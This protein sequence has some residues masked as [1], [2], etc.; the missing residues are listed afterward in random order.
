MSAD[1]TEESTGRK[2]GRA[3]ILQKASIGQFGSYL[4][5][6]LDYKWYASNSN[7]M[8]SV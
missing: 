8:P 5:P 2:E 1:S 4:R 6:V 7:A 3:V